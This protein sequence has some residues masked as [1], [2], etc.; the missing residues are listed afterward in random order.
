[1]VGDVLAGTAFAEGSNG[2]FIQSNG[3]NDAQN[4][5][6][7]ELSVANNAHDVN[8]SNGAAFAATVNSNDF[9]V[10]NDSMS[11]AGGDDTMVGDVWATA[12]GISVSAYD[13][14]NLNEIKLDA[15]NGAFTGKS[16]VE[17]DANHNSFVAYNDTITAGSDSTGG[18]VLVGDVAAG[19]AGGFFFYG[20]HSGGMYINNSGGWACNT[21]AIDLDVKDLAIG[22]D[23]HAFANSNSFTVFDDHLT[24]GAGNNFIVGDVAAQM[25]IYG[26]GHDLN[27]IDLSIKDLASQSGSAS[28]NTFDAFN[29]TITATGAGDNH[30]V[31]DVAA[32]MN[33]NGNYSGANDVTLA[34]SNFSQGTRDDANHNV[35]SAWNDII[36][37]G[38]GDNQIVGDVLLA[39]NFSEGVNASVNLD[40]DNNGNHN[41]FT[42]MDDSITAGNGENTIV[43]DVVM[44]GGYH[45]AVNFTL[46][47]AGNNDTFTAWDDTISS[48]T[49]SD[50]LIGDVSMSGGS[51]EAVNVH[52]ADSGSTGNF[53]LFDNSLNGGGGSDDLIVGNDSL[54]DN[55]TITIDINWNGETGSMFS[56]TLIGGSGGGDSLYGDF[57]DSGSLTVNVNLSGDTDGLTLFA[58]SLVG[59]AGGNNSLDGGLGNDTL[60]GGGGNDTFAFDLHNN[61]TNDGN[62]GH[63]DG[64]DIITDF[65]ASDTLSFT[66]VL[67]VSSGVHNFG[68]TTIGDDAAFEQ[69]ISSV[70][71]N[72]AN[73]V[74]IGFQNGASVQVN[75]TGVGTNVTNAAGGGAVPSNIGGANDSHIAADLNAISAH[76]TIAHG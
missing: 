69:S 37:V 27:Q 25:S 45:E 3:F 9:N 8:G 55:G 64:N 10:F 44:T 18:S 59:G 50:T 54:S 15:E 58:D 61:N 43:G 19:T 38:N 7:I 36:T 34:I 33:I 6:K 14:K 46:N 70:T 60:T 23:Y 49:G 29:D 68:G 21:N 11:A 57:K 28:N 62:I 17:A 53:N 63:N 74:T 76:I 2:M 1:M 5:N 51:A 75:E 65:N 20:G 13:P 71:V 41:T 4:I 22:G 16:G 24:A 30:I 72:N 32:S 67:G 66:D 31:G 39:S 73:Q 35:F 40:I 47:N 56:D 26:C 42:V 12:M 52:V 48:G